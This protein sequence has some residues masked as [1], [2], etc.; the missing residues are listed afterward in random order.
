MSVDMGPCAALPPSMVNMGWEY[1]AQL[2]QQSDPLL[3]APARGEQPEP[4]APPNRP[5][6]AVRLRSTPLVFCCTEHNAS[7]DPSRALGDAE[8]RSKSGSV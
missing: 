3:P 5:N 8:A 6:Q 2:L 1:P 7:P 4:I